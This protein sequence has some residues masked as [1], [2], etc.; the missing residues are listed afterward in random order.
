MSMFKVWF[1]YEEEDFVEIEASSG[2]EAMRK[3]VKQMVAEHGI[4]EEGMLEAL[5]FEVIA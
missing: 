4:E 1:D 2:E 3:V 5:N